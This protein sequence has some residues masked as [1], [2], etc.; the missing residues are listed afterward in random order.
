MPSCYI[1]RLLKP[2]VAFLG[3]HQEERVAI[4]DSSVVQASIVKKCVIA[5]SV[6]YVF[7]SNWGLPRLYSCGERSVPVKY[8]QKVSPSFR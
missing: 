3:K 8:G 5:K 1:Q 6:G 7:A 4:G 2:I